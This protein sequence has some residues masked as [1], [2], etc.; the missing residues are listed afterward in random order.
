MGDVPTPVGWCPLVRCRV[1]ACFVLCWVRFALGSIC[2][3]YR[4]DDDG[5]GTT[6][7]RYVAYVIDHAAMLLLQH[8]VHLEP[9]MVAAPDVGWMV[10]C[11]LVAIIN[12]C[13]LSVSICLH[14]SRAVLFPLCFQASVSFSFF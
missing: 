2:I 12:S 4:G 8:W 3:G 1:L 14:F 5:M 6:V 11:A 13:W 7:I 10:L 9:S